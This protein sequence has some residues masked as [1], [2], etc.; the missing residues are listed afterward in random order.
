MPQPKLI[1][2]SQSP[3]RRELL[4]RL[5]IMFDIDAPEVDERCDLGPKEAVREI[6]RRKAV[7]AAGLHP[8]CVILAADTLVAV[9]GT[10]LGKP[11]DEADAERMLRMLSGRSHEVFTGVCAIDANGGLHETESE[12]EVCF[13]EIPEDEIEAYIKSG[14]PMDKAGAYAMQGLA[15]QWIT[16]IHG[17]PTGVI[18][19][20]LE[21]T[22]RLLR[23][24]GI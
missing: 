2:A 19:L 24:C 6:C 15:S 18:G 1:L 7:H 16:E 12:T 9:D 10:P 5:G 14:E 21:L 11:A 20:P 13:A 23:E 17:S 8:G 22:R 4:S 3:R